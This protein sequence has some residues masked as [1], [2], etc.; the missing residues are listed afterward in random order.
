MTGLPEDYGERK[1]EKEGQR[2]DGRDW[3]IERDVLYT[4]STSS[5]RTKQ[6]G[7]DLP[8]K[9]RTFNRNFTLLSF[10]IL[11]WVEL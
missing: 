1:K 2:E 5:V 10:W 6:E 11:H 9:K 8:A 3:E 4:V 7:G